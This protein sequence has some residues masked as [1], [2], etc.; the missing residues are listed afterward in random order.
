MIRTN[1]NKLLLIVYKGCTV[2]HIVQ[3]TGDSFE[4]SFKSKTY[5]ECLGEE[6]DNIDRQSSTFNLWF[7]MK[8]ILLI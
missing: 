7:G 8:E 3:Q 5:L 1:Y 6:I 4:S 2:V